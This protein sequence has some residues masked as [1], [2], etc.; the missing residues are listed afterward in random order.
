MTFSFGPHS[1]PG[2]KFSILEMKVFIATLLPQFVFDPAE[3]LEVGKFNAILTRPYVV[4]HFELGTRLP[5]VVK[6]FGVI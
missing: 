2:Y 5:L 6:R 4:D 1:C 3:G